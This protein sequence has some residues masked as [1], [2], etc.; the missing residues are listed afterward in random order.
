MDS[1]CPDCQ[2]NTSGR[3]YKHSSFTYIIGESIIERRPYKCPCCDGTGKV[4][5]PPHL[6]GDVMQWTDSG[7]TPYR[8]QACD[9]KGVI[10][11]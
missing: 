11:G 7:S 10:W 6:A 3:C 9:G 2:N 4:S 8:C 1:Y 5:R